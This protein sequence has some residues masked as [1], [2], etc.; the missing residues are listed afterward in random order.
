MG[1]DRSGSWKKIAFLMVLVAAVYG[2]GLLAGFV[3]D[4]KYLIVEKAAFFRDPGDALK[5]LVMPDQP[6]DA[7][8]SNYRLQNPFGETFPY[9]RPLN[10]LTYMLDARLWGLNPFWYHLENLMLHAASVLVLYLL[11]RLAFGEAAEMLAFF[12]AAIWAVYPLDAEP[13]DLISARNILLCFLLLMAALY[14][15][16]KSSGKGG[17]KW[18]WAAISVAAFFLSFLSKEQA[19]VLP[20]FLLS[21]GLLTKDGRLR[22]DGRA[23]AGF[24]LAGGAYFFL[25]HAALGAFVSQG[26]IS[27][28]AGRLRHICAILFEDFKLMALPFKLN[29]DYTR[30]VIPF[31]ILKALAA[32]SGV[33]LLVYLA[34]RQRG[35]EPVRAG[36]IWVLWGLAPVSG[37]VTIPS[38]PVADR[39]LYPVTAGFV[40]MAAW[41]LAAWHKRKPV[42]AMAAFAALLLVLGART[43]ERNSIWNNNISLYG[44][45]VRSDPSNAKAHYNLGSAY[46]DAGNLA[47]AIGELHTAAVLEPGFAR[48]HV[49]LG[50]A[51]AKAGM[52]E[53]ALAEFGDAIRIDPAGSSEAHDD[54]GRIYANMGRMKDAMAEF[55]TAVDLN[56]GNA[57]ALNNLGLAYESVGDLKDAVKE[58]EA[59][60]AVEPGFGLAMENLE[61]ARMLQR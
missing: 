35:P 29:A 2:R 60:L 36:A 31:D 34:V 53:E 21:F 57:V 52:Y 4:D 26:G 58:F 9:Y 20:F 25:R 18:V 54:I 61:R 12:A 32:A 49:N 44:S 50:V 46:M 19:A 30:E 22:T 28:S 43:F 55:Q 37:I 15:L 14:F 56:P 41:G 13:V 17:A 6:L 3:W 48:I 42:A 7:S 40:L 39:Y 5:I 51:Y 33:A 1:T 23:I 59:A 47:A 38:S 11:I 24:F 27:F 16:V 8:S 45:M 10:T